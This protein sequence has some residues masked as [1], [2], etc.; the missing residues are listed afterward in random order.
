MKKKR[1]KNAKICTTYLDIDEY[2]KKERFANTALYK[3]VASILRIKISNKREY[4]CLRFF[5]FFFMDSSDF[6][7]RTYSSPNKTRARSD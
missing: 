3:D 5:F 6:D 7:E 2:K 4:F 1:A